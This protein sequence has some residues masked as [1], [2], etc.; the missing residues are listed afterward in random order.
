M[1]NDFLTYLIESPDVYYIY[2]RGSIIY[3]LSNSNSDIDFLVIVNKEFQIPKKFKKYKYIEPLKQ[4]VQLP[5][6]VLYDNCDF[7][8]IN[9]EE[10]FNKILNNDIIAW[11]SLC[12]PKQ[13]I[14]KEYVKLP[15]TLDRLLL[16]KNFDNR[17][18]NLYKLAIISLG[19]EGLSGYKKYLWLILKDLVF[20]IQ[21]IT[22]GKILDFKD[23]NFE[24][25]LIDST[26]DEMETLT[27]WTELYE[28]L[29]STLKNKTD[30]MLKQEKIK[31]II[32]N[33]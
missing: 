23:A 5:Y 4:G 12:L 24:K 27:I 16:R 11:E 30:E 10:W 20:T 25:L 6:N 7:I 1:K 22:L 3:G 14:H 8:F 13:Y 31:K 29:Y 21:I 18:D 19:S 33:E 15:I 32:Q 2:N 17:K 9:S 26:T 28:H